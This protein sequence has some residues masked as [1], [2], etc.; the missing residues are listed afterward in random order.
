MA[1]LEYQIDQN[2]VSLF[3]IPPEAYAR[4]GL[5]EKP[6]FKELKHRGYDVIIW[7]Q[8]GTGYALVSEIGN[9]SCLVC[10]SP[11]DNLGAPGEPPAPHH[12]TSP[13]GRMDS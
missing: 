1:A 7:R 10:H 9:R 11:H 13:N 2:N 4:L 8:H 3:V 6:K 5:S 12:G